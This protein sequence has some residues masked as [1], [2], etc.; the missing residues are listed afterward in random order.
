MT[1]RA[2]RLSAWV[3]LCLVSGFLFQSQRDIIHDVEAQGI[4]FREQARDASRRLDAEAEV[5]ERD[6]C[7]VV[8]DVHDNARFRYGT[9]RRQTRNIRAYL[10]DPDSFETPALRARIKQTLP[11]QLAEQRAAGENVL[12]TKPPPTC[13]PHIEES[14]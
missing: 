5:R 13:R 4:E 2:R 9:E 3:A 1:P 11:N 8:I 12:A 7:L 10:R 14:K 6:L